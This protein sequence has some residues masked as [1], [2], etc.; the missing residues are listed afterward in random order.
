[1]CV[2]RE[3]CRSPLGLRL[4]AIGNKRLMLVLNEL[5]H[6]QNRKFRKR[7]GH[8]HGNKRSVSDLASK[9]ENCLHK[10][11]SSCFVFNVH[12]LVLS[13]PAKWMGVRTMEHF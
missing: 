10:Y 12:V 2:S 5:F 4:V 1:M 7:S 11:N 9:L 6:K 13:L 8:R 3:P